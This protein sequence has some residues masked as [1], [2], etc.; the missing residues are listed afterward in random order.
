[1]TEHVQLPE[2]LHA[3]Y[4]LTISRW[5]QRVASSLVVLAILGLIGFTQYRAANPSIEGELVAF[6]VISSTQI[7]VSWKVQRKQGQEIYCAIRA[8]DI[9]KTDVGYAIVRLAP[10]EKI[11]QAQY[12]V[13][14][15]GSAVLAE[16]LGCG[17]TK[18]LRVPPANFPPG[19][20]IPEQKSPGFTP[21]P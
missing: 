21:K 16:V 15:N 11:S 17:A 3:R 2:H 9:H 10:G 8:Q 7:D 18:Q 13:T 14:T 4:G 5:P 20:Q 12:S 1:M 19:V 6:K